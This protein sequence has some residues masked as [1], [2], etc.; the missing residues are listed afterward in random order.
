[1]EKPDEYDI[2]SIK[3][4]HSHNKNDKSSIDD[5]SSND[6]L[7]KLQSND[8]LEIRK[9][10]DYFNEHTILVSEE[11]FNELCN[12]LIKINIPSALIS[13]IGS[14][15]VRCS[16]YYSIIT[17]NGVLV[18]IIGFIDIDLESF[19]FYSKPD[20]AQVAI[21]FAADICKMGHEQFNELIELNIVEKI[22]LLFQSIASIPEMDDNIAHFIKS[23]LEACTE[24]FSVLFSYNSFDT[25]EMVHFIKGEYGFIQNIDQGMDPI[26]TIGI[27]RSFSRLFGFALQNLDQQKMNIIVFNGLMGILHELFLIGFNY[28][29]TNPNEKHYDIGILNNYLIA[30]VNLTSSNDNQIAEIIFNDNF[31]NEMLQLSDINE[32]ILISKI[33]SIYVNLSSSNSSDIEEKLT[34]LN[35]CQFYASLFVGDSSYVIKARA[36]RGLCYISDTFSAIDLINEYPVILENCYLMMHDSDRLIIEEVFAFLNNLIV[37]FQTRG[38]QE[39]YDFVNDLVENDIESTLDEIRSKDINLPDSFIAFDTEI[40]RYLKDMRCESDYVD[41]HP[42]GEMKEE[43][44]DSDGGNEVVDMGT[45]AYIEPPPP[46][47]QEKEA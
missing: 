5:L 4:K 47:D 9:S 36:L 25:V 41:S 12:V 39:M 30:L 6:Y 34:K 33:I 27:K 10:I 14:I 13:L 31:I 22:K 15:V 18:H 46:E 20:F 7:L 43:F 8:L 32:E 2:D 21:K 40:T 19:P 17:Y 26:E 35:I 29:Q 42:A 28:N 23:F 44:F 45:P 38:S 1:M 16:E 24:L 11:V 37:E 3:D